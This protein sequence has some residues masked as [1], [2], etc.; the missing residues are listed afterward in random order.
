MNRQLVDGLGDGEDLICVKVYLIIEAFE[1][2][3]IFAPI[4]L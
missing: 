2:K 4:E 1:L 3:T